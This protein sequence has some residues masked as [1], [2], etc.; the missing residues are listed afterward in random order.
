MES[1][2]SERGCNNCEKTLSH[3][4]SLSLYLTHTHTLTHSLSHT[5]KQAHTH[6]HTTHGYKVTQKVGT[7][8]HIHTQTLSFSLTHTYTHSLSHTHAHTSTR[9]NEKRDIFYYLFVVHFLLETRRRCLSIST[10][11]RSSPSSQLEE[12][13]NVHSHEKRME[14]CQ[15]KMMFKIASYFVN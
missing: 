13:A 7:Y 9:T 10:C 2:S 3:T 14:N 15:F 12:I 8:T 11:F 5:Y 1:E 6:T 4:H